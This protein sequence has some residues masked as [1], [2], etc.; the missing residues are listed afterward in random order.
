L[1]LFLIVLLGGCTGGNGKNQPTPDPV[2][3]AS[4][5]KCDVC[6]MVIEEHHGPGGQI[7]YR[8]HRPENHA[9]PFRFD[10]LKQGLLPFY[11]DHKNRGWVPR[12]IYVT[13]YSQFD[14]TV[15][16][17]E[18]R[19][20]IETSVDTGTFSPVEEV[21]FVVGSR[22]H[23]AMG[24][25]FIPFSDRKQARAFRKEFGGTMKKWDEISRDDL[26]RRS[27][28]RSGTGRP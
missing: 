14:Y 7:F 6:G 19:S 16:S 12:A 13:D 23:G 3:L 25:D 20:Y 27:G 24:P 21:V 18:K 1:I 9:E 17:V 5:K 26:T 2:S 15:K 4:P 11:F 22:V 8:D 10:S 28:M